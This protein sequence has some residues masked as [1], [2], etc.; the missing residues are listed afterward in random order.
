MNFQKIIVS[1]L[2]LAIIN[3]LP[4]Q[5]YTQITLPIIESNNKISYQSLDIESGLSSLFVEHILQDKY[6]FMWIATP[7]G[8]NMYDGYSIKVYKSN[9]L[10]SSS[11]CTDFINKVYEDK[12]GVIWVC[13]SRGLSSY[14]RNSENFQSYY[15]NPLD[16]NNENNNIL[17][18]EED[19]KGILWVFTKN[20]LFSF[21][22]KDNTFSNYS[23]DSVIVN[24]SWTYYSKFI[25]RICEDKNSNVW[26]TSSK[27]LKKFDRKK[28][29]FITYSHNPDD[30]SSISSN[31]I[32]TIEKDKKGSIWFTT[33][34]A[35]INK[36]EF[37]EDNTKYPNNISFKRYHFSEQKGSIVND[38][39]IS[40]LIDSNEDLWLTGSNGISKYN[41]KQDNFESYR[42]ANEKIL[43]IVENKPGEY[44]IRSRN[45]FFK[46]DIAKLRIMKYSNYEGLKNMTW[47]NF[48]VSK[49]AYVWTEFEEYGIQ[50]AHTWNNGI[51]HFSQDNSLGNFLPD[52]KINKVL[53]DKD[54]N[55]WLGTYEGLIKIKKYSKTTYPD[56]QIYKNNS[57]DLKS[58]G[59]DYVLSICETKDG[60]LWV[61]TTNGI[62]KYN[63]LS[64]N[65]VNYIS[66]KN[67]PYSLK[68][69]YVQDIFEDS[70]GI[71]WVLTQESLHV[72]DQKSNKFHHIYESFPDS[73]KIEED[74]YFSISE[75][76]FGDIWVGDFEQGLHQLVLPDT[77]Y[78]D[79]Y[80]TILNQKQFKVI[81]HKNTPKISNSLSGNS[82]TC[83]YL[84][85]KKRF[86]IGTGK[87]LNLYIPQT[88]SFICI[89]EKDGLENEIVCGIL[90]DDK[91][92][93]WLSTKRGISKI[94]ILNGIDLKDLKQ[95]ISI[96][97]YKISDGLQGLEFMEKSFFK[98]VSGEMFF[99]GFNGFNFFYPD[100]IKTE[101][102]FPE[103]FI[104]KFNKFHKRLFFNKPVYEMDEIVLKHNEDVFSFEFVAIEYKNPDQIKYKYMLE[105]FD[106]DW[107][108]CGTQRLANYTS[109]PPG[110]YLFRV[111]ASND[112][113]RWNG[114]NTSIKITINP[115]FWATWWFRSLFAFFMVTL[116]VTFIKIRE[117]NLRKQKEQLQSEV[118]ER[119]IEITRKNEE[120]QLQN[121]E[122]TTQRDQLSLQNM[123][124]NESILY[125]KRIQ[126]AV[127]PRREYI[128]EIL[129]ENFILFKP[130]DVVSGD[131]YWIRQINQY[132]VI[133]VADCTG[134]GVPG[135]IMSMLG[136]SFLNEIVQKR[137]ITQ[138]NQALNELRKQVKHALKQ[139][140]KKGETDD[141]MDMALCALNTK[142]NILQ[143]AGAVNSLY[144]IKDNKFS[145]IKADRMPIG[146]YPNEKPTFT[147]H[148]IQLKD[149]DIFYLFSDGFMDQ[150]GGKKGFK[151]KTG[152]F[153]KI[154]YEN[155]RKPMVVQKEL[156]E[157]ELKQWM[158]SYE[159]TDDILVMGV[160]V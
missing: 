121:E 127:L 74:F 80:L 19:S 71:L 9:H 142:T 64:N 33:L 2:I 68:H 137:E 30:P 75:D 129:P 59:A 150:F 125:A 20:A 112:M 110:E 1:A 4:Y 63:K 11:L 84:D 108:N 13:T 140:G 147:N 101:S 135:A 81:N 94:T 152:N 16:I 98:S 109:I 23:N 66:N 55:L 95:N 7:Y 155:H 93:I 50:I 117:K 41:Y 27:G 44:W 100:S 120:L 99:G 58:L 119:T 113:G 34:D 8:L 158:K 18:V 105:G 148:E 156:L 15:P 70:R 76:R 57:K 106:E 153:Q 39:L 85:Q 61:G 131:F 77:F 43:K 52:N 136:I 154:L 123:A 47:A 49:E 88:N 53:I 24:D 38:S 124:I 160:R 35:G 141:G 139:T 143:Y 48:Y 46:L 51:Q 54:N 37:E 17:S 67:D 107:I 28:N 82:I 86:W 149:G 128:D 118:N 22:R 65:F 146:F 97:N 25:K 126:T 72:Y 111:M 151:Y 12:S 10:D 104:T 6:G 5:S 144:L 36:I 31:N 83:M 29:E 91:G 103:I 42:I 132:V 69:K 145:E 45:S 14:N 62:S 40:L 96:T 114:Q 157:Q 26:I 133:A 102:N 92:N 115:P 89:N 134:H 159:Q 130:R 90:D 56:Y 87:G 3:Y 21:N 122:I 116:L 32:V 79:N 60:T 73:T 138:T 78:I